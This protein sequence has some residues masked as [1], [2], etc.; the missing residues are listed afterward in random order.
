[1]FLEVP[2]GC[3]WPEMGAFLV[4]K[5]CGDA[6]LGI[7]AG[8][9]VTTE[10]TEEAR[11]EGPRE[12]TVRFS[13]G[14]TVREAA[15]LVEKLREGIVLE[16]MKK[17]VCEDKI[18]TRGALR[19]RKSGGGKNDGLPVLLVELREGGR[20]NTRLPIDQKKLAPVS[21]VW[22]SEGENLSEEIGI[23]ATEIGQ[24]AGWIGRISFFEPLDPEAVLTENGVK[25]LKVP[26]AGEGRRIERGKGV[27]NF[28]GEAA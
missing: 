2:G 25:A 10:K 16:V 22:E 1:M 6:D 5:T 27:E 7:V 14:E 26:P 13:G 11:T 3:G 17:Q 19:P 9:E 4:T 15:D 18:D 20:R 28:R 21:A 8:D 12:A 24:R 23:A